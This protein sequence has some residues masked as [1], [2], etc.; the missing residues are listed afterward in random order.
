VSSEPAGK[1]GAEL[2]EAEADVF[3]PDKL[4]INID[5]SSHFYLI[6]ELNSITLETLAYDKFEFEIHRK[7]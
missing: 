1:A 5:D 4:R 6:L 3:C 2:G 7:M